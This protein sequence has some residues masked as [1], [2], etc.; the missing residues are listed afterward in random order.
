MTSTLSPKP[1]A[2]ITLETAENIAYAI[3]T[4][5]G[6]LAL[7]LE[8]CQEHFSSGFRVEPALRAAVCYADDIEPLNDHLLNHVEKA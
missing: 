8:E 2:D 1:L 6:L 7:G 3:Y 4:L 5:R